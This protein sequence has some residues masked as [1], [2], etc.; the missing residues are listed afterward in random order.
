MLRK[1]LRL[2]LTLCGFLRSLTHLLRR[3]LNWFLIH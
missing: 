2:L 3:L 1:L